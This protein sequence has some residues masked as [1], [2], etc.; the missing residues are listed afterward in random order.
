MV[1]GQALPPLYRIDTVAGTMPNEEG[2]AVAQAYLTRPN[3]ALSDGAGGVL[4]VE[5]QAHRIRRVA[6][7]GR[8]TTFAGT[9]AFGFSG[10]DGPAV[11]AQLDSPAFAV[12]DAAGNVYVSDTKNNRVRRIGPDG[13]ITTIAGDGSAAHQGDDLLATAASINLPQ[14]LAL[15]GNGNLYIGEIGG[16]FNQDSFIRVVNL[17][18]GII[19]AFAGGQRNPADGIAAKSAWVSTPGQLAMGPGGALVYVD[20]TLYKVRVITPRRQDQDAGRR[21]QSRRAREHRRWRRRSGHSGEAVLALRHRGG[22]ERHGLCLGYPGSSRA[23]V[24]VRRRRHQHD[25][26]EWR[27]RIRR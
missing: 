22:R 8:I 15:D 27:P 12:R 20:T 21:R 18:T 17:D 10:D 9:G 7:D 23:E 4:I 3:C 25:R 14:G 26:G 6:A 2:V 11:Q 19:S 16:L 24:S 5:E 1:W 13:I